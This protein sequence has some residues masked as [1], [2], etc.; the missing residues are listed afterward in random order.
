MQ[1]PRGMQALHWKQCKK[2]TISCK[3]ADIHNNVIEILRAIYQN[4]RGFQDNFAQVM[5]SRELVWNTKWSAI[6]ALFFI[7]LFGVIV[8]LGIMIVYRIKSRTENPIRRHGQ[9]NTHSSVNRLIFV[10]LIVFLICEAPAMVVRIVYIFSPLNSGNSGFVIYLYLTPIS[11]VL[12]V[13]NSAINFPIYVMLNNTFR[14]TI[15]KKYRATCFSTRKDKRKHIIRAIIWE[16]VNRLVIIGKFPE[17]GTQTLSEKLVYTNE[18]E[19]LCLWIW[20]FFVSLSG[21]N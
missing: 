18:N 11:D 19:L 20:Q 6:R 8:V 3:G 17:T 9:Q 12:C 21:R 2:T 4:A 7:I 15:C 1:T 16:R 10:I 14:K 13:L 5:G